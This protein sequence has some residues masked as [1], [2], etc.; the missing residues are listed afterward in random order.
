[1]KSFTYKAAIC[2]CGCCVKS[3]SFLCNQSSGHT[4]IQENILIKDKMNTSYGGSITLMRTKNN[5]EFGPY[6][7]EL[8][9]SNDEKYI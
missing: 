6:P 1:M 4:K 3:L 9:V 8:T 7:A 2:E 5:S